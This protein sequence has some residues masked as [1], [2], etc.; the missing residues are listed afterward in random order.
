V[1]I[2]RIAIVSRDQW[3]ALRQQDV[4]ASDVAIVCGEGAYG[5]LAELYAEKKGLRPPLAD[6]PVLRRGRWDEPA[7]FEALAEHKPHWELTRAKIYLRDSE[8]RL[9]ATPDGYALAPEHDGPGVVQAKSVSRWIFR[10][11]WMVD[12]GESV[13]YGEADPPSYYVLQTLAEMML[14]NASWGMLAVIVK[15]EFDASFRLFPIDRDPSLEHIIRDSV[16][17]FWSEYLDPGIMPPFDPQRDAKLIKLLYHA[18]NGTSI[19]LATDNRALELVDDLIELQ[20]A[21]KRISKDEDEIKT[22]LQAKLG[23]NTFGI[24]RDGR[25]LSWKSQNRR[26]YVVP[27]T[28]TRTLRILKHKP[29][30]LTEDDEQ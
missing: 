15:G 4:T 2:E 11:R 14:S 5:S 6:N 17:I 13:E 30:E 28:T 12:P 16:R 3:L 24:L 10:N 23:A 8:L 20:A 21:R 1:T 29:Q 9:G 19:D 26:S 7:V 25:C 22:E 27:A 18:D